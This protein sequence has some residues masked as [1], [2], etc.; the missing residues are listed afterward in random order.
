MR[1]AALT[2][3]LLL[4]AACGGG[5]SIPSPIIDMTG[6]DVGQHSRDLAACHAQAN[7]T[8]FALGNP[9]AHCMRDKGYSVLDD[10]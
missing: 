4:V 5:G 6:V 1:I 10:R 3:V 8:S 9:V 2:P 7:R